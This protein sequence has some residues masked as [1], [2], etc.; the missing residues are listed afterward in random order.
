MLSYIVRRVLYSILILVLVT[1]AVFLLIRTL[2][3]DPIEMLV[4]QNTL[5]DLSPELYAEIRHQK[6]LDRPLAIQYLEW[7]GRTVRGDFGISILHNFDISEALRDRIT[8]T[9]LLG[10][11]AFLIAFVVGVIFG[12]ICAIRR[13][14]LVDTIITLL[15]NIGIT[16]PS[17]WIGILLIYLLGIYL[18]IL[19][20][21]GYTLP[22]K[23]FGLSLRQ[24]IMP[25]FVMALGPIA[26][27]ARQTRSSVLEVINEDYVRTAW[28]KG[29]NEKKVII[30]H[31]IKNAL[32]PI[33]TLQGTMLR[34]IV[35]G[36]VVVE[37][38]FVIPGM[39]KM[40]VDAIQAH[41]YPVVQAVTV[42]M[43]LVVV[44]SSL[45]VDLL[46]GWLD[47]RIQYS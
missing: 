7:A 21:Y 34:M 36:S 29:L 30:K 16:A 31:V 18:K 39:G 12:I 38:V 11:A 33:V 5:L 43:T 28:A 2:P 32:L 3:G 13:G 40:M 17:F 4:S 22:G 26:S 46:Y 8:V 14:K 44:V 23:D 6:G 20:I 19:P 47:P 25:I 15:A 10:I 24:S 41:D 45:V 37:T 27:T 9:L 1:V 35:G 42:V